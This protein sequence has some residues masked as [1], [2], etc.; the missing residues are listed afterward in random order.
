MKVKLN[1][2]NAKSKLCSFRQKW[3]KMAIVCCWRDQFW[4]RGIISPF[5]GRRSSQSLARKS[6]QLSNQVIKHTIICVHKPFFTVCLM[7]ASLPCC[8]CN[9]ACKHACGSTGVPKLGV[10]G[11][12]LHTQLCQ[13]R[14]HSKTT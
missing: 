13:L 6:G 14:G 12:L 5:C 8:L 10:H 2:M 9:S 7:P 1:A 3:S 4:G 11:L